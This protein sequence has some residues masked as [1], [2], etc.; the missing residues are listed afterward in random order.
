MNSKELLKDGSKGLS[1]SVIVFWLIFLLM[2]DLGKYNRAGFMIWALLFLITFLAWKR[3][4][5]GGLAYILLSILYL[6]FVSGFS[7]TNLMI[8][9]PFIV[10]GGIFV[11]RYFYERDDK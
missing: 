6:V 4:L 5:Y 2:A 11:G 7:F 3:P 1:V 10:M 8:V 9:A